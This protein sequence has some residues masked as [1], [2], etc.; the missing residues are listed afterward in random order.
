MNK[1]KQNNI[2]L[3]DGKLYEDRKNVRIISNAWPPYRIIR[4]DGEAR[5]RRERRIDI[6]PF[7]LDISICQETRL[8]MYSIQGKKTQTKVDFYK[9]IPLHIRILLF[10]F[11]RSGEMSALCT[12]MSRC[13]SGYDLL[14]D[15]PALGYMLAL[16]QVFRNDASVKWGTVKS[17]SCKTDKEIAG[18]LGWPETDEIAGILKSIP[19]ETCNNKS[20]LSFMDFIKVNPELIKPIS[21]LHRI[22]ALA[23]NLM[24]YTQ[25]RE[26]CSW[27]F[28]LQAGCVEFTKMLET[29]LML[30]DTIIAENKFGLG[31][32][33]FESLDQLKKRYETCKELEAIK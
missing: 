12:F 4:N 13:P 10:E 8:D 22:N 2:L 6:E 31:G 18:W 28:I 21:E 23:I 9:A 17:W 27:D 1:K 7:A 29:H 14:K 3:K 30:R 26:R 25:D 15:R 11:H 19:Y 33:K 32:R 5:W 16:S 20:L 24:K